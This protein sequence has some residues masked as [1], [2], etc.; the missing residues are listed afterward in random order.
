MAFYSSIKK[1]GVVMFTE[2]LI[3]TWD[4]KR[5]S[6]V[7]LNLN[8]K[9]Q[10]AGDVAQWVKVL[11]METSH[12]E[13]RFPGLNRKLDSVGQVSILQI[14]LQEIEDGD[15]RISSSSSAS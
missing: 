2:R 12:T 1:D 14:H 9:V 4:N 13:L 11:A 15:R 5:I 10:G 8:N 6:S 3:R 7:I